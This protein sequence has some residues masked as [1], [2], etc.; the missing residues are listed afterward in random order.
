MALL[1]RLL[2]S[3]AAALPSL[4][5]TVAVFNGTQSQ[6]CLSYVPV[7]DLVNGLTEEQIQVDVFIHLPGEGVVRVCTT[8]P[9]I[10]QV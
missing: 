1:R 7:D 3:P 10:A 5:A 6:R 9:P 4:R 8:V 2:R